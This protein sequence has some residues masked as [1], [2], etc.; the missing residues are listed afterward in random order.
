MSLRLKKRKKKK[1][2]HFNEEGNNFIEKKNMRT[3]KLLQVSDVQLP[4][5]EIILWIHR[6]LKQKFTPWRYYFSFPKR[7]PE[8]ILFMRA[9]PLPHP[10]HNTV[11]LCGCHTKKLASDKKDPRGRE[12]CPAPPPPAH[13]S[14]GNGTSARRNKGVCPPKSRNQPCLPKAGQASSEDVR[15]V[16]Q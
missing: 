13:P 12:V 3:G 1:K 10:T 14:S 6:K 7:K 11:W 9:R 15:I 5:N 4:R 16:R 8:V 2:I